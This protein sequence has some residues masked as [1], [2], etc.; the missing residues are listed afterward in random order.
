MED[1]YLLDDEVPMVHIGVEFCDN[2]TNSWNIHYDGADGAN[3]VVVLP[4][5]SG[6]WEFFTLDITNA[7][8]AGRLDDGADFQIQAGDKSMGVRQIV[9]WCRKDNAG[10]VSVSGNEFLLNGEH[11]VLAGSS[12][13]PPWITSR[14]LQQQ[15]WNEMYDPKVVE[16]ELRSMEA[17]GCNLV[18][19][20][21][22]F[23]DFL[24]P[25]E[26][27]VAHK[28]IDNIRDFH[29]RA[30]AHGLKVKT[31]TGG[32]PNWI[33]QIV[34]KSIFGGNANENE[35][36]MNDYFLKQ[37][38]DHLVL[39]FN[40]AK[41]WEYD[42][43]F[44]IDL[45]S[46]PK[47][48]ER[49]DVNQSGSVDDDFFVSLN[50]GPLSHGTHTVSHS[51]AALVS[52]NRWIQSTYGSADRAREYWDYSDANDVNDI[53][54][55]P[56]LEQVLTNGAWTAKVSDYYDFIWFRVNRAVKYIRQELENR[57]IGRR[58]YVT[59]DYTSNI[60]RDSMD[61]ADTQRTAAGL[62]FDSHRG[63]YEVD[64]AS[65]HIYSGQSD[66]PA[67]YDQFLIRLHSLSAVKP[68]TLAEF[69]WNSFHPVREKNIEDQ[70]AILWENMFRIG[71]KA[72]MDGIHGWCWTD[73][74]HVEEIDIPTIR[75]KSF[76]LRTADGAKKQA[77]YSFTQM[78]TA[79]LLQEE[80]TTGL[81][82]V[83][84]DR[85]AFHVP[86]EG[87]FP[88]YRNFISSLPYHR[89]FPIMLDPAVDATDLA[90]MYFIPDGTNSMSEGR[91]VY[92]DY[93]SNISTTVLW[94]TGTVQPF[95]CKI[96]SVAM[97][98][99]VTGRQSLATTAVVE[100]T[101]SSNWSAG[102]VNL[103]LKIA[104]ANNILVK[105]V[106][107]NQPVS[108]GQQVTQ[109]VAKVVFD[110]GDTTIPLRIRLDLKIGAQ[111][112]GNYYEK[113]ISLEKGSG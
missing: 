40:E 77:Y 73:T 61:D 30:E 31:S 107:I 88:A 14:R 16:S 39:F 110:A 38:A 67:W 101:G 32:R 68:V 45:F 6:V 76:G 1:A 98:S 82:A 2:K 10:A 78:K 11:F 64:F 27:T 93:V 90:N 18:R 81:C 63:N 28:I 60:C 53:V 29:A 105:T 102:Q 41:L 49:D 54:S 19:V 85:D 17:A 87:F 83:W 47:F 75:Q 109:T 15:W 72:G 99:V 79:T 23:Q 3:S 91:T 44:A 92:N 108:A 8:F 35:L 111:P 104:T 20:H 26:G 113:D 59:V 100:N 65:L 7:F 112:F 70:Q 97:P 5:N 12:W 55:P 69:G 13:Q 42:S 52:W 22:H 80:P 25:E 50:G 46:E 56:T 58:P 9:L 48:A 95:D 62:S 86:L 51:D 33:K 34:K 66:D 43:F 84:M 21:V 24:S 37:Y 103:L 94:K 106:T 71:T 89:K 74:P 96:I 36:W 4:D 57:S